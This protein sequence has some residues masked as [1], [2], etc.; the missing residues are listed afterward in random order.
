M[1]ADKLVG[2]MPTENL[3][4]YF[5]QAGISTGLNEAQFNAARILA[6]Q[7]FG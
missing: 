4:S 7:I 3:I 5:D 6:A 2:N 1:A